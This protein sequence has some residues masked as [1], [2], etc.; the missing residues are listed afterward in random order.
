MPIDG[1]KYKVSIPGYFH[2]SPDK[3]DFTNHN[4]KFL[5]LMMIGLDEHRWWKSS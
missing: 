3:T 4:I 1:E 5:C 2:W